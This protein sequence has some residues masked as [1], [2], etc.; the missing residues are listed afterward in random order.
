MAVTL[1]SM[2]RISTLSQNVNTQAVDVF[3]RASD[4]VAQQL[5]TTDVQLSAFGQIKAGFADVQ[6]AGKNLADPKKTETVDDVKKAVQSF[7]DAYNA[8]AK[9]VSTATRNDGKVNGA[10]ADDSRAR[11]AGYDLRRVVMNDNNMADLKKIGIS[12]SQDGTMSVD[13]KVLQNAMQA[14]PDTVKDTLARIGQQAGQAAK[15]ELASTGNVGSAVDTL[16]SRAKNLEAQM[17][18]QQKLASA[19]QASVQRQASIIGN[20]AA[21]GVAAYMQMFSF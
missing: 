8:T 16:N 12:I 11:L 6:S 20:A 14:N 5:N 7:A 18:E 9:A 1:D 19:S 21:S 15:K 4:R 3:K 17:T 13:T 10:L 2:V